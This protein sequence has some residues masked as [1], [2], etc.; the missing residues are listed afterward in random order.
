MI[1]DDEENLVLSYA[2]ILKKDGHEVFTAMDTQSA[3]SL[4]EKSAI[5][6]IVLDIYFDGRES[7]L[8]LLSR[9]KIDYPDI[10]VVMMT[11]RPSTNNIFQSLQDGIF[12]FLTKPFEIKEL[13]DAVIGAAR[14]R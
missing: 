3:D 8:D 7:G 13:R 4:L 1:V 10:G 5:D 9:I 11:G 6:V 14:Q 2:E 12:T